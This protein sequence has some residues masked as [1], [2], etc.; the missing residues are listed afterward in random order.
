M[1][2]ERSS[3]GQSTCHRFIDNRTYGSLLLGDQL[4]N[5]DSWIWSAVIQPIRSSF[6]LYYSMVS[7]SLVNDILNLKFNNQY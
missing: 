6:N 7:G 4:C 1:R 5:E 3:S 2:T